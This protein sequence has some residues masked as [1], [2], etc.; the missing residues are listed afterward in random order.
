MGTLSRITGA[1]QVHTCWLAGNSFN[2]GRSCDCGSRRGD[3]CCGGHRSSSLHLN[4]E[5]HV[6]AGSFALHNPTAFEL[7]K[8]KVGVYE[9]DYG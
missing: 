8:V 6:G 9:R 3:D 7:Q 1:E 2:P 4:R 5:V